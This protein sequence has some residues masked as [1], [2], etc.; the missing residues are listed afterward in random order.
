MSKNNNSFLLILFFLGFSSCNLKEIENQKISKPQIIEG[1]FEQDWLMMRD[2]ELDE[3]PKE[4]LIIAE[5]ILLNKN[6]R[7]SSTAEAVEPSWEE[8]GPSNV[9]GRTRAILFDAA[10]PTDNT[11]FAAG[12]GGG[13]WYTNQF[14]S[15]D[16]NWLPVNDF[17]D[18]IAIT[19]IAQSPID[20]ATIYFGTGE[21]WG[22][23]DA[24]RGLGIWK[25]TDGG[26]TWTQLSST[27][28]SGFY[29]VNDIDVD[30]N[31]HVF[32]TTQTGGVQRSTDGGFTWSAVLGNGYH[33][34]DIEI[35]GEGDVWV[36]YSGGQVFYSN[37]G[38][39]VNTGQ[40]GTWA[41]IIPYGN[42]ARI[43]LAINPNNPSELIALC[44]GNSSN[45][46]TAILT[47]NNK[48]TTWINRT[49]P[50][51]SDQGGN[52]IFTRSQAWYDL[53]AA[54]DPT[55][56][57]V[58]IGGIDA[59]RSADNGATWTQISIWSLFDAYYNGFNYSQYVHADHHEIIF[60]PNHSNAAV[61]G[62]DGGIFYSANI[63]ANQP[64][65]ESKNSGYN[66]T[67]F[68][69]TAVHPTSG[70]NYFLAGAQDNGT[71]KF[72]QAGVNQTSQASGGD[73]A[74]CHI[75]ENNPSIQ[76]SSYTNNNYY[77]STD[78]GGYF[79]D[80]GGGSGGWFINPT[81][82][83]SETKILY[84]ANEYNSLFRVTEVGTNNTKGSI[85]VDLSG[86]K[87][88]AITVDPMTA[89]RIWV[90]SYGNS[91]GNLGIV[92]I[93]NAHTSNPTTS[94]LP[95][96]TS[97]SAD[98]YVSNIALEAGN[99]NHIIVTLSNF[100]LNS[101]WES[102]DGGINWSSIEG[103]LPDM[104]VRWAIF[105]PDNADKL[106]IATE[107]GV[108]VTTNINGSSTTWSPANNSSL[109]N[110]RVDML[111]YRPADRL[112]AV[113]THG[114]GLFTGTIPAS[115]EEVI[116]PEGPIASGSYISSG[117]I[118]ASGTINLGANV[119]FTAGNS[120][121]LSPPFTVEAGATFSAAI[122]S[123]SRAPI[124]PLQY[125]KIDRKPSVPINPIKID[126]PSKEIF[127]LEL[128]L[129]PNPVADIAT[130]QWISET[131]QIVTIEVF[132][133]KG[134][135]LRSIEQSQRYAEGVQK[136]TIDASTWKAGLYWITLSLESG[137]RQ[138]VAMTKL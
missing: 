85:N 7:K 13:L 36:T 101:I 109:P 50:T 79:Y 51:I 53:I 131:S 122:A 11:V 66:V 19:C 120:I 119:T 137:Q 18:N 86:G 37:G 77:V 70:T 127:S 63:N 44:Q 22:N 25:S 113:A 38:Y 26:A 138:T 83:D 41:E 21:G 93:D 46:V 128:K 112:L 108:W 15:T 30:N 16:P 52:S 105:H 58:F 102:T 23:F 110:T 96:T 118:T 126:K 43:E 129:F 87:I 134:Q 75:D 89:N 24:I 114:R 42:Y 132:N 28:N 45:N 2:L 54:Y 116:I 12:V 124:I 123:S 125:A 74:F 133:N 135:K 99:S 31:G 56:G 39:G 8:R 115:E 81:D 48:G 73:G 68:Y 95:I 103:D 72:E 98:A 106:Y 136:R 14:L 3:V 35:S 40:A 90:S 94:F 121:T 47:T 34:Q 32:A 27:D 92:R 88:S 130:L 4:R 9:G 49:V 64:V 67:Q 10:D 97:V 62:T 61:I 76:I 107:L 84:A 6:A 117:T 55:T 5:D 65:F 80:I 33:F 71:Q 57:N 60:L 91:T 69:A 1:R 17:F 78:G 20:P 100:G 82:Y 111:Q 29:Y 59:L 104:P